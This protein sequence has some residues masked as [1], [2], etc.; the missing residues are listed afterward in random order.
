M[1]APAP[2]AP[3]DWVPAPL[4]RMTVEQYE[5]MGSAGILTERDKVHLIN[6]YLVAKLTHK[7]PH[8]VA[9][10]LAGTALSRVIPPGWHVRGGKPVR[11]PGQSSEPEPD[12]SVVRGSHRDYGDHHP[13]P[14]DI[15]M[16]VE[17]AKS[18]LAQ[19]REMAEVYG[20]AG[21]PAYWIINLIDAQVEVYS[22]PGP[23]GYTALEILAPG[24]VLTVIIDRVEVGQIAVED[25]LP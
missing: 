14:A 1:T 10:E 23:A 9:D 15:A 12:R 20:R 3:Q 8:A 17:V 22:N 19:D 2:A 11:L 7:P 16:V 4:Y 25:I 21:I 6:G 13:G 24:H 5:A 18:S